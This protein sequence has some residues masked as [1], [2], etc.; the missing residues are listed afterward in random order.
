[1]TLYKVGR[2]TDFSKGFLKLVEAGD[3]QVAIADVN[4]KLYA[5]DDKCTHYGGHLSKGLLMDNIVQCP[6]H[7]SQFDVMTGE[8]KAGPAVKPIKTYPVNIVN[9]EVFIEI[10]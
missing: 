4:G 5:F 8:R 7:G 3:R 9:G 6:L 10:L 2:E 1:M